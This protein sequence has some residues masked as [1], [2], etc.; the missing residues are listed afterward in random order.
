MYHK[1]SLINDMDT[2]TTHTRNITY[3]HWFD[4]SSA[5]VRLIQVYARVYLYHLYRHTRLRR[6]TVTRALI[7]VCWW[8]VGTVNT[9]NNALPV[10]RRL[11]VYVMCTRWTG[12]TLPELAVSSVYS[13]MY[14]HREVFAPNVKPLDIVQCQTLGQSDCQVLVPIPFQW[15]SSRKREK[16]KESHMKQKG[17]SRAWNVYSNMYTYI[18]IHF[19]LTML[20]RHESGT[21]WRLVVCR[22]NRKNMRLKMRTDASSL[23]H[24]IINSY[25]RR[26][27]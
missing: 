16:K 12:L 11:G 24:Y 25:T 3:R 1:V 18:I 4:T 6:V 27:H 8:C 2:C 17:F 26:R 13:Y 14:T 15:V 20:S 22:W 5:C 19:L 10:A 21:R 9:Q 7:C 23:Q